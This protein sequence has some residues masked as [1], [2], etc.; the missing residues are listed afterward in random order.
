LLVAR[1]ESTDQNCWQAEYNRGDG[2]LY[3]PNSAQVPLPPSTVLQGRYSHWK[4]VLKDQRNQ[5]DLSGKIPEEVEAE[6]DRIKL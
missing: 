1:M 5:P 2:V 6:A 4:M 3:I